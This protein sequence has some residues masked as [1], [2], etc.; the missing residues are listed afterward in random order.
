[1]EN[2]TVWLVKQHVDCN[3]NCRLLPHNAC[4]TLKVV[5]AIFLL[6]C[7]LSLEERTWQTRTNVFYFTSK[8]LFGLG[9]I[10]I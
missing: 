1:M 2:I 8:A 6:V 4:F 3:V 7:F 9:K 10:K 5:S